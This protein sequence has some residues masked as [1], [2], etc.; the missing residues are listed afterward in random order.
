MQNDFALEIKNMENEALALKTAAEYTSVRSANFTS[1]TNVYTGVYQIT[2]ASSS[3][4]LF[5]IVVCGS[6]PTNMGMIF[7][8]TPSGN[9][10]TIEVNTDY[11][12]ENTGT[13]VTTS[14]PVSVI[15]NR[16]VTGIA[17]IS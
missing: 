13:Y 14:S 5:T 1:T 3:E 4:P 6:N 11:Y 12:D 9:T 7:P 17:R 2:Y 15:S 10:Q 16:A 8:H